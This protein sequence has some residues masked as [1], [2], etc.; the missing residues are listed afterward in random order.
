M[1]LFNQA[2]HFF[3]VSIS[4]SELAKIMAKY[5]DADSLIDIIISIKPT[6]AKEFLILT[7]YDIVKNAKN[8]EAYDLLLNIAN[9]MGYDRV[10]IERLIKLYQ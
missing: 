5:T 8:S 7:C 10:K 4:P 3:G 1:I 9:D 6:K 2:A